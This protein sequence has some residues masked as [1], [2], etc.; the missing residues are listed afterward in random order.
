[1]KDVKVSSTFANLPYAIYVYSAINFCAAISPIRYAVAWV[2]A[3][4][5]TISKSTYND[6]IYVSSR[7][8]ERK[9]G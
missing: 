7:G 8:K 4:R 3:L 6:K 5:I 9:L 1:M 2:W